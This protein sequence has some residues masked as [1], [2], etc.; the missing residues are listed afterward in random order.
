M[1]LSQYFSFPQSVSC[2]Q[3]STLIFNYTLL[4]PGQAGEDR[5]LPKKR[6]GQHSIHKYSH[7][8]LTAKQTSR[9]NA[10]TH[11]RSTFTLPRACRSAA[12]FPTCPSLE[13]NMHTLK[14]FIVG[15][16]SWT[17]ARRPE[18]ALLECQPAASTSTRHSTPHTHKPV[19]TF[20]KPENDGS[21]QH[22][23]PVRCLRPSIL[24]CTQTQCIWTHSAKLM[25]VL[26]TDLQ[27]AVIDM[28]KTARCTIDHVQPSCLSCQIFLRPWLAPHRKH[29]PRAIRCC[30]RMQVLPDMKGGYVCSEPS[31]ADSRQGSLLEPK[32][33]A[34]VSQVNV[35]N[36]HVTKWYT[37][38]R[39]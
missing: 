31:A 22:F 11:W 21:P 19:W 6:S 34:R 12:S 15:E 29:K 36:L 16:P 28:C 14:Q 33:W 25:R 10:A 18:M 27:S 38:R 13:S 17:N 32:S 35:K 2:H 37:G 3:C 23:R 26:A 39:T 4:L 9:G 5:E 7:F 30:K 24:V 1:F 8:P 20:H